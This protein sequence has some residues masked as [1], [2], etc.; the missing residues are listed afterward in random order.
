[1][2][3]KT[4]VVKNLVT[5]SKLPSG[6]FVINSYIG[7][8]HRCQYCY[9]EFM[10]RFTGHAGEVWGEFLDVKVPQTPLNLA[11]LAGKS[12]VLG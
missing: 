1:M 6:D 11:K 12:L 9:A 3:T 2:K 4:V 8:S 5:A 10:R 7:C